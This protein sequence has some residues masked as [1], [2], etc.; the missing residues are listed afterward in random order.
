MPTVK[1]KTPRPRTKMETWLYGHRVTYRRLAALLGD[2][3]EYRIVWGWAQGI[4]PT[5]DE[6]V[7]IVKAIHALGHKCLP[8]DLW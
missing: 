4:P 5:E 2:D 3:Y 1:P 8:A 7:L 6:R